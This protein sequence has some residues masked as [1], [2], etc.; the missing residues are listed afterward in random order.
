MPITCI[1]S[2]GVGQTVSVDEWCVFLA[3]SI[4]GH[5]AFCPCQ[6]RLRGKFK[7]I[8]ST[9]HIFKHVFY[10]VFSGFFTQV[11]H[12]MQVITLNNHV[13]RKKAQIIQL[14]TMYTNKSTNLPVAQRR[15]CFKS[16]K[17]RGCYKSNINQ[18]CLILCSSKLALTNNWEEGVIFSATKCPNTVIIGVMSAFC[19]AHSISQQNIKYYSSIFHHP[20]N[21]GSDTIV[22]KH[23]PHLCR[24]T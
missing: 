14:T 23:W 6:V 11:T 24:N 18:L 9:R 21:S 7:E 22:D 3:P 4:L 13:H 15:A 16:K 1:A 8:C 17:T 12:T 20:T 10:L 5:K 2:R 19:R